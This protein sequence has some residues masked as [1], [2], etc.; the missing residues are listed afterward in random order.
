M[1]KTEEKFPQLASLHPVYFAMVM[2]TG[3]ISINFKLQAFETA[4][5][6]LFYINFTLYIALTF[7]FI[8]RA[9]FFRERFIQD[10]SDHQRAPG[11]F[12][13]VA[14]NS[15][16][17]T[18]CFF[19]TDS[20]LGA[21]FFFGTALILWIIS[22]YSIFVLL[23]VKSEKPPF[24]QAIHGGWL[25]AIVAT[26]SLPVVGTS[27]L[28]STKDNE[29]IL[30]LLTVLWLFGGMLYI[31]II[32]IIFYRYMFFKF[33]PNDLM[34]PYWINMGAMAISSLAG[35]LLVLK[36]TSSSLLLPLL[37]FIK[38]FTLMFWATATWWIPMLFILG[39]WRHAV[40]KIPISYTPLYWGLVFPLG[41][42]SVCTIRLRQIF[43]EAVWLNDLVKI[44][45]ILG[46]TTWTI[47]FL[48]ML[49][50]FLTTVFPAFNTQTPL[51]RLMKNI[52]QGLM[53][54][55][56][57]TYCLDHYAISIPNLLTLFFISIGAV[58]W[59]TGSIFNKATYRL[60]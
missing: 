20:V 44:F 43:P 50:R 37:P 8:I 35:S 38:G 56:F 16:I 15:I 33:Y 59:I 41:M 19:M 57:I 45:T 53:V 3:I 7:L 58:I 4:A 29:L 42:Y 28:D 10:C 21:Q 32:S 12:T 47:T 52:G 54:T 18:Q 25:V 46:I 55:G 34:P 5:S 22:I 60:K 13:I 39:F 17:G 14:A 36:S 27:F 11:F 6:A 2:A 48:G 1:I 23:T 24:E 31:W 30:F 49:T 51:D 9:V 26:Q 40:K